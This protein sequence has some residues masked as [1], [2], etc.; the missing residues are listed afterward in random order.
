MLYLGVERTVIAGEATLCLA[1][2]CGAGP[3]LPSFAICAFVVLVLH[4]T[5]AWL[6]AKDP[7]V[8]EI[9]LRNRGYRDFY[10]P[11]ATV[12]QPGHRPQP[13]VPAAR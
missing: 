2:I 4:P 10:L 13:S 6:T 7:L 8:V 11:H 12:R 5:M 3:R 1:L 9:Y